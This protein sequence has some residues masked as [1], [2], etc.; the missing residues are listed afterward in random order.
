MP[1]GNR[2]EAERWP[3]VR[4]R[5]GT[6]FRKDLGDLRPLIRSMGE[7]GLLHPVVIQPDGTLVAGRRRLEAALKLGWESIPA[8]VLD[9]NSVARAEHDENTVRQDFL[10]TESVAIAR[11]LAPELSTPV[12]RP[13]NRIQ[14]SF[15]DS[16]GT[17]ATTPGGQTRRKVAG[18]VGMSD[19]TLDKAKAVVEAAEADPG[20][21][22]PLAEEMDRTRRVEG[23]YKRLRRAQQ[24]ASLAASPP[25][26]PTGPFS[27]LVAD[28][29]WP[30]Y[31]RP[32]DPSHRGAL[33]YPEMSLDDI[34]SL[35]VGD[36]ADSDSV[37][38]LWTTNAHM[39]DA[40]SVLDAWGFTH[41]T[42]LTWVK[43]RMGLGDWLRG[44]T[45]HCLLAVRGR[46]VT[47][48][49]NQTTVIHG[50]VREHS[51][52]PE[53]FYALVEALCPG[54]KVELFARAPREGWVAH[55]DQTEQFAI[56]NRMAEGAQ[57]RAAGD[58]M[59]PEAG[60][61]HHSQL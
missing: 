46:P 48:L 44:Q 47:L 32:K 40:F 14:E 28:P 45:E 58:G 1:D 23:A 21:Y 51:R 61:A 37:L 26:L 5:I 49:T 12:G 8:R 31:K 20:R 16:I 42:I 15:L 59:A 24:A 18:Y 50:P 19:R 10:P 33:P 11:A 36:L 30:Y 13:S 35:P 38:W 41:K 17:S 60:V 55:G 22:G 2:A 27:V 54:S 4:I 39:P 57:R 52:K 34:R 25:P 3:L 56:D 53:S 29:P 7:I 43:D 9:F 6:R